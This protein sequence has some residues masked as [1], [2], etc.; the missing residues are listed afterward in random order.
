M[1][2]INHLT[3]HYKGSNKGVTDINLAIEPGDIYAFIGH[4][5][6]GKTTTLKCVVGIHGF[7]EGEILINGTSIKENPMLCKQQFAYIPDNPDLYEYLTGIQYLNFVADIFEVSAEV[8]QIR[9]EKYAGAFG[10]TASLGD[11]ISSYSHGMKQ[12]LALISAMVHEPKLLILDEPFVGLDPKAAVILK[13]MMRELCENGGAIFFSTHVLDVAEKLC[14][15]VAIIKDGVLI[16]SGNMDEI[17]KQG[18]SLES[19]FMEVACDD[20]AN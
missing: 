2:K 20:E 17:V 1:L 19:I 18:E 11:L 14:N 9:I 10:I 15:K 4:N 12:K 8:R 13:D 16:A 3:K 7:D 5:G 6:A